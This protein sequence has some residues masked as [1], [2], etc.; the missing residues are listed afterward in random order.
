MAKGDVKK[1]ATA[2]AEQAVETKAPEAAPAK[3]DSAAPA[4]TPAA[5][6]DEKKVS[7]AAKPVKATVKKINRKAAKSV[8]TAKK[9]AA[10]KPAAKPAPKP[11]AR[12]ET[13]MTN[14]DMSKWF[15]GYDVPSTEKVEELMA[16]AGKQ[17]EEFI[18]KTRAGSEE[19]A[20]LAKAN[21]EAVI[22]ATKIAATGAKSIGTELIEDGRTQFEAASDNLR[23]LA[24]AKNPQEYMA[25]QS[26]LAKSQFDLM[27]AEGSKLTEKMV[28]LAG[29]AMQPV[30][31]RA[32]LNV[33]K[34]KSLMA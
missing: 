22:E 26:E 28:K 11:A 31:N 20:G 21:V 19:L 34:V 30:S 33:E 18:A 27:V 7:A 10:R 16:K 5:T 24:E 14:F 3:V 17:G 29:D 2:K 4:E 32:S 15:G 25:I 23:R 8:A 6:S 12:K 9:P 1:P 13:S